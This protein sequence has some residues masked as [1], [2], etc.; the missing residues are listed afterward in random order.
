MVRY[1]LGGGLLLSTSDFTV[2]AE[3]GLS[4]L[5]HRGDGYYRGGFLLVDADDSTYSWQ[6]GLNLALMKWAKYGYLGME[7]GLGLGHWIEAKVHRRCYE[8]YDFG[9]GG[10]D[11]E[12]TETVVPENER[13]RGIGVSVPLRMS[14]GLR[15]KYLSVGPYFATPI[16]YI[17]GSIR[18]RRAAF[19]LGLST[20]IVW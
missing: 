5:K 7:A 18:Q 3:T 6:G 4:F 13:K 16:Q 14:A 2:S 1:H 20:Q 12:C 19:I 10:Y 17:A 9:G 11:Y 8:S 15:Y